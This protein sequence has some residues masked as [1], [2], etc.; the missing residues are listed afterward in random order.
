MTVLLALF[1]A[2]YL[3]A[4]MAGSPVGMLGE[5]RVLCA[6]PFC[7][8]DMAHGRSCTQADVDR[9]RA[10]LEAAYLRAPEEP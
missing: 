9:A 5:L 6:V 10:E 2:A 4:R 8:W 3:G 1:A 7:L